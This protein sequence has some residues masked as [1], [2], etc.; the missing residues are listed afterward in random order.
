MS[1]TKETDSSSPINV[2]VAVTQLEAFP[3]DEMATSQSKE[4]LK[5]CSNDEAAPRA[6][7]P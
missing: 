4:F 5:R 1:K 7:R 6:E 3:V 2:V